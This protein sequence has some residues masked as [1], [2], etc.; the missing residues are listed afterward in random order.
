MVLHILNLKCRLR[1]KPEKRL[2]ELR[3][4]VLGHS[5]QRRRAFRTEVAGTIGCPHAKEGGGSL[6][7]TTHKNSLKKDH[8]PKGKS[9]N[10]KT[11]RRKHRSKSL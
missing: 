2:K 6:P 8:R 3:E 10:H 1:K 4:K 11:L 5:V 9:E 7:H